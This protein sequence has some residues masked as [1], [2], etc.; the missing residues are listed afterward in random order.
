MQWLPCFVDGQMNRQSN[1]WDA[2]QWPK[3]RPSMSPMLTAQGTGIGV[4]FT[5]RWLENGHVKIPHPAPQSEMV[6]E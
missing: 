5:W 2:W 4:V 6:K 1:G 3:K